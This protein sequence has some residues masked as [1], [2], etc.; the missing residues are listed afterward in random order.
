MFLS[1]TEL[2]VLCRRKYLFCLEGCVSA[3]SASSFTMPLG[4]SFSLKSLRLSEWSHVVTGVI[5]QESQGIF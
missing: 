5:L 3:G 1:V 4:H 2:E